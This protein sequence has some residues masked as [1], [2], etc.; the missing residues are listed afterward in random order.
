MSNWDAPIHYSQ[1]DH[2]LELLSVYRGLM[3]SKISLCEMSLA[4]LAIEAYSQR[5]KVLN[6]MKCNCIRIVLIR[7]R[8]RGS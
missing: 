3:K 5:T 1:K 8:L 2:E 6:S 4:K 7:S